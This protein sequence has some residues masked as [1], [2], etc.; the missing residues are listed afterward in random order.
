MNLDAMLAGNTMRE[1]KQRLLLSTV[2][3]SISLKPDEF[4]EILDAVESAQTP[5]PTEPSAQPA[6]SAQ[7]RDGA[8]RLR[9]WYAEGE[10]GDYWPPTNDDWLEA[11]A[12]A[13]QVLEQ[14]LAA[15]RAGEQV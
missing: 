8:A 15:A 10:R 4:A 14:E 13:A 6:L 2:M 11:M 12:H 9:K 1:W 5:T 3:G 7:L